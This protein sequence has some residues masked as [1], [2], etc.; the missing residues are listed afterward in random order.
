M[1]SIFSVFNNADLIQKVRVCQPQFEF[2]KLQ[3]ELGA[4]MVPRDHLRK[5]SGKLFSQMLTFWER[6]MV[7][8]AASRDWEGREN[9]ESKVERDRR[10]KWDFRSLCGLNKFI[11]VGFERSCFIKKVSFQLLWLMTSEVKFQMCCFLVSKIPFIIVCIAVC[12]CIISLVASP[13]AQEL[14]S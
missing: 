7:K 9:G 5:H 10:G 2:G 1:K 13:S 6:F 12:I 11:W 4:A 8:T 3:A 14:H